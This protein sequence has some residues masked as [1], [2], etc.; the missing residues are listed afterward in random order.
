[1]IRYKIKNRQGGISSNQKLEGEMIETKIERVVH[2]GE[3]IKDGAPLIYT[4][5]KD[6]VQPATNI[7][8][9]RFEVAIEAMDKVAKSYTARRG[10][11]AEMKVSKN[12]DK[13]GD[14]V[15]GAKSTEGGNTT[16]NGSDKD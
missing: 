10:D 13:G 12:D 16:K 9:D 14:D 15:G 11:K 8:T 3:P 6:G 1:M 5:R 4:E 7:R 2:S